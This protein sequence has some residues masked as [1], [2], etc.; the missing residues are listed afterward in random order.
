MLCTKYFYI[1]WRF[2][3]PLMFSDSVGVS[4]IIDM[5]I[6]FMCNDV[7]IGALAKKPNKNKYI[8]E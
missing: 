6:A 1:M 7:L 3:L 2:M 4:F 8:E 5:S